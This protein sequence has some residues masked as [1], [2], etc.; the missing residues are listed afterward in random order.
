MNNIFV[1]LHRFLL[2]HILS[3]TIMTVL[4]ILISL[5]LL[6]RISFTEDANSLIPRDRRI[7]A[8]AEVFS[9]S[10]FAERIIV[11]FSMADSSVTDEGKLLEAAKIFYNSIS[12]DSGL[13]AGI[14][15]EVDQSHILGVY[16]FVFDNLPLYMDDSDYERL[17][18]ILS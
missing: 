1:R 8:I 4:F 5:F 11:T 18:T 6:S 16:D 15:F 7:S 13:I 12:A 9:S 3:V 2:R 17:D 10:E 14:D